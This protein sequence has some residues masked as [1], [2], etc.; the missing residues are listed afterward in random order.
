MVS[1]RPTFYRQQQLVAIIDIS[2]ISLKRM[3][4]QSS[5]KTLAQIHKSD[6]SI[7]MKPKL[8]HMSTKPNSISLSAPCM[9]RTN[10]S[11]RSWQ[12]SRYAQ[13][14]M[15]S[16]TSTR[17]HT[18]IDYTKQHIVLKL[19]LKLT[20]NEHNRESKREGSHFSF[21]YSNEGANFAYNP[22][23]L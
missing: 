13:N 23:S 6:F 7:M 11:L 12:P 18:H 4:I 21:Y 14:E 17:R 3:R 22:L 1:M 8:L 10:W 5:L 20:R 15:A 2:G 9:Q 16:F 19:V